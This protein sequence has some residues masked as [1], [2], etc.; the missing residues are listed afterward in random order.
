MPSLI[1]V[2]GIEKTSEEFRQKVIQI[3]ANLLIDPNFLMAIMSF[4]S[5]AS[6][7]PSQLNAAGSHAIGLIQFMPST[8]KK[9]GT[10]T[11]ELGA[12]TPVRQLDFV[13]K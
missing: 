13:E 5:G 8:A 11:Q 6:F 2:P 1:N 12:M 9:L 4:E 3:A 7:S 10:S